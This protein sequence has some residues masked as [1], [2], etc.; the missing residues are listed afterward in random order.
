[1]ALDS[2]RPRA[3]LIK[4]ERP[5]ICGLC[6]LRQPESITF[7]EHLQP[8]WPRTSSSSNRPPRPRRSTST[9]ARTSP[10]W[11]PT[12][13][14]ATWCRR[15]VRSTRPTDF[16]MRYELIEKNE[17][18]VEAIAKAAKSADAIYPGDRP[19][20]RRRGD[21]LAHRRDPEG[22]RPA[23]GQGRCSAWSSPRS[24]P[25]AI[26]EA[27]DNPRADRRR[28]GRCPAGAARAGLP[29]RLQPVAGAVA[30]GAARPVRRPRAVAGAA[31]DRRARGR[32]RSLHRRASTGRSR[33]SCAHPS[34]GVHRPA[35][36]ARRQEVRTVHRHRRRRPPKPR[37][38]RIDAA[39][40]ATRC[41][42]P[43]SPARNA[44]AVRRRRSPPPR[45]SRKP[46]ASSASP[47]SAP[48]ASRRNCT[49][50]WRSARKARSA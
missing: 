19:G 29:G 50:A 4:K 15:K 37:A 46:R 24:R 47:P 16:A 25:R 41:T 26:K 39:P 33:P 17:K 5:L 11:P 2:S 21:Q 12:A 32:D 44:S 18:H 28:P 22:A 20:S 1:M 34:A 14:S 35:G 36:Q 30:Q 3:H 10:S 38:T 43:T 48:C 6:L 27:M 13:M 31:H 9:W 40:P 42:S 23:Q 7:A 49:K 8:P 45:C